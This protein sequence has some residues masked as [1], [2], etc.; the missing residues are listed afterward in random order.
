MLCVYIYIYV[1]THLSLYSTL[2][3]LDTAIISSTHSVNT[4]NN[5]NNPNFRCC[6]RKLM[7]DGENKFYR[8][9]VQNF[10]AF[11]ATYLLYWEQRGYYWTQTVSLFSC[12]RCQRERG[13]WGHSAALL[14]Q[15]VIK[16]DS[17]VHC[18]LFLVCKCRLSIFQLDVEHTVAKNDPSLVV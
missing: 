15:S 6:H 7:N 8:F 12:F 11:S 2:V 13:G 18:H 3:F 4:I 10:N 17:V 14:S 9:Y 5:S 1:H 16:F